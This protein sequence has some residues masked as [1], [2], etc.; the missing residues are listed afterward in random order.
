MRPELTFA[1][2]AA[3]Y[4]DRKPRFLLKVHVGQDRKSRIQSSLGHDATPIASKSIARNSF[5]ASG[6][7]L[8]G[9]AI[10]IVAS[11]LLLGWVMIRCRSGFDFTDEG[12]Y[13]NWISDPWRF[14]SSVTQFGFVYY[15]LYKLVD[16]DIVL[17]R[18]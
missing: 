2:L 5:F 9:L 16:G 14:R 13:L 10:S 4:L 15:P 11:L 1:A 6:M 17:L 7:Q 12:F 3:I 8:A 18:Q